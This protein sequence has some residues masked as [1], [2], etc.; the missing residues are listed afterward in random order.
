MYTVDE[1]EYLELLEY[2]IEKA[3]K[4]LQAAEDDLEKFKAKRNGRMNG[5][6]VAKQI[7][8]AMNSALFE[9]PTKSTRGSVGWKFIIDEILE[10]FRTRPLNSGEII[11]NVMKRPVNRFSRDIAT[12]SV[13][14]ALSTNS[15][16]DN[17]RYKKIFD[18]GVY[19]YSLNEDHIKE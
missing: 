10:E 1:A 4:I 16:G 9:L 14:S 2:R 12:K 17:P 18:K 6:E 8:S 15:K 7:P 5:N 13:G 3:K 11:A 19:Y